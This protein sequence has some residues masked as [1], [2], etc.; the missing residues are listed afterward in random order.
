MMLRTMI[1]IAAIVVVLVLRTAW[2][3]ITDTLE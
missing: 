2:I 3:M 1:G